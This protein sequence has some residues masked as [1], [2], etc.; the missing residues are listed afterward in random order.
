MA[1]RRLLQP[2]SLEQSQLSNDFHPTS[3]TYRI[4]QSL[5][6]PTFTSRSPSLPSR[7]LLDQDKPLT[8]SL[9]KVRGNK[10]PR[11]YPPNLHHILVSP[12]FHS[13]DLSRCILV[14]RSFGKPLTMLAEEGPADR[15][16]SSAA[17]GSCG[18]DRGRWK[19]SIFKVLI[20]HAF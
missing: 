12:A 1:A 3:P 7:Y 14:G 4:R 2:F 5:P 15:G 18:G 16:G 19:T 17:R 6:P 20:I 8:D 13:L 11:F 10:H 9:T